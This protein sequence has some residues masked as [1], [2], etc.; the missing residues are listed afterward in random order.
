VSN[1]RLG[2]LLAVVFVSVWCLGAVGCGSSDKKSSTNPPTSASTGR[3]GLADFSGVYIATLK[4][5]ELANAA[6]PRA[7]WQ[8]GSW[9][10]A[11]G[12]R[13]PKLLE[14]FPGQF[15]LT[16]ADLKNGRITF[17]PDQ[18]CDTATG[19]TQNS[20][21]TI[22]KSGNQVRFGAVKPSCKADAAV[23]TLGQWHK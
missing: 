8:T 10:M 19:R 7:H 9:R 14:F 15:Q 1:A 11:F 21:F 3:P 13:D 20:V 5:P 18:G 4:N 6:G 17:A 23:L 2:S 12:T 16:V 22:T